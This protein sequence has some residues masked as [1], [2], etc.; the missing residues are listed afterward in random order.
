MPTSQFQYIPPS[1][2]PDVHGETRAL[3]VHMLAI[4]PVLCPTVFRQSDE[5]N[6][7]FPPQHG[8][9]HNNLYRRCTSDWELPR[10]GGVPLGN[11][12]I[13]ANKYGIYHRSSQ[14]NNDA[15]PGN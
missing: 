14:I 11:T 2:I 5:T 3:S 9:E 4:W 8:S 7:N 12:D 15:N 13:P 10:S 1:P 6:S